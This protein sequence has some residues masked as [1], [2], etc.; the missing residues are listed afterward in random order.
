MSREIAGDLFTMLAPLWVDLADEIGLQCACI[1]R[2][3]E[4]CHEIA[5]YLVPW[6]GRE[7]LAQC[8]WHYEQTLGMADVFSMRS[9]IELGTRPL[10][11]KRRNE[12]PEDPTA[13][14]F[15]AMELR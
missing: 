14:R 4:R 9:T 1:L 7:P 3:G 10:E 13:A 11:V 15:A 6:P 8:Q 2:G 5:R 12:E